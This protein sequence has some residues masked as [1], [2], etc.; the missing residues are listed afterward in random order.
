[1]LVIEKYYEKSLPDHERDEKAR[2]YLCLASENSI[3]QAEAY[4]KPGDESENRGF[5]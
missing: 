2:K 1:M 5:Y 3:V 4:I